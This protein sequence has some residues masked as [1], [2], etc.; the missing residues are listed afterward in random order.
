M[1]FAEVTDIE[2]AW[3]TLSPAEQQWAGELLDAAERWPEP[4]TPPGPELDDRGRPRPPRPSTTP[5]MWANNP[6]RTNRR[7]NR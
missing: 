7:R 4:S 2:G 6:T 5:P 1:A 3:R